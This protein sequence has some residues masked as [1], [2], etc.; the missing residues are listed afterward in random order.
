MAVQ[1]KC[2][3]CKIHFLFSKTVTILD[4]EFCL[5]ELKSVNVRKLSDVHCPHCGSSLEATN[6]RSHLKKEVINPK[7][8][9]GTSQ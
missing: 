2:T 5:T 8:K 9:K 1:G 3:Q 6:H 7:Q 4:A